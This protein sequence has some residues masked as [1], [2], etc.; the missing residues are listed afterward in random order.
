MP[1]HKPEEMDS[2]K[3]EF[4][5]ETMLEPKKG[6]WYYIRLIC[7]LS[8]AVVLFGVATG[9]SFAFVLNHWGLDIRREDEESMSVSWEQDWMESTEEE[10]STQETSESE[11]EMESA[12]TED[13]ADTTQPEEKSFEEQV[14]EVVQS[15]EADAALGEKVN[16]AV[17]G[18]YDIAKRSLVTVC[19]NEGASVVG[20]TIADSEDTFGIIVAMSDYEA[21]V[22]TD[23]SALSSTQDIAVSVAGHE[24]EA[25]LKEQDAL[26][27]IVSLT[28]NLRKLPDAVR[29]G[30]CAITLGNSYETKTG[31]RVLLAGSPLGVPDSV[32]ASNI[33]YIEKEACVTDGLY[34]ILYTDA[35]AVQGGCGVL[36]NLK[37]E[38]IGWITSL[39]RSS[40]LSQFTSAL[41]ISE[42]KYVM[43]D[44]ILGEGTGLLGVTVHNITEE[45][46]EEFNLPSGLYV[47]AVDNQTPAYLV[48]I[49]NG[50]IITAVNETELRTVRSLQNL[51]SNMLPEEQIR[52]T[53][54]RLGRDSY[55]E[56]TFEVELGSR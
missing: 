10:T 56:V 4:I 34:R 3:K 9:A 26:T 41:G 35:P 22:L 18:A 32:L 7:L 52:V 53:V 51:L 21:V 40:R 28:V 43:E 45:I 31:D 44:L 49:Q 23:L 6:K 39:Y 37:G 8:V 5:R 47:T 36:L 1:D 14:A 13:P 12:E 24:V 42:L 50:D 20:S 48:G 46:A 19:V 11:I 17:Y 25:V 16:D 2:E 30:L 15:M 33:T 38:M 27:G 55:K 54:M 29:Q